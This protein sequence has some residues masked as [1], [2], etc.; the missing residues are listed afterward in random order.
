VVLG[1]TQTV[2]LVGAANADALY[3]WASH[4]YGFIA[5]TGENVA[6]VGAAIEGCTIAISDW[7][8]ANS[9][10]TAGWK[11]QPQDGDCLFG[12]DLYGIY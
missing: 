10:V 5:D 7:A 12:E 2:S 6:T 4:D 3:G 9:A 8:L 1:E 11:Q